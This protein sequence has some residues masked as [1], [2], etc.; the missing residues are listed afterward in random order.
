VNKVSLR[1]L[2]HDVGHGQSVHA[3]TPAGEVVVID[4]GCSGA[5]SPLEWL[6][7]QTQTID[8]LIITHPHG[9]HIDE[10]LKI[11]SLG[12]MVRQLWRPI[13]L[14]KEEVYKQNQESYKVKIERY[15]EISDTYNA[16]IVAG[17]RVGD[18][19]VSG[20]VS[21]E[22]FSASSCGVS[23]INNHSGVI[24]FNYS[25]S[26]IIIPGDN[27]PASWN[28]LKDQS[29][30]QSAVTNADIFMASHHGRSSGYEPALFELFKP[31]LCVVSDGR[32]QDTDATSRYSYHATGWTV[33]KKK[34][35]VSTSR[36]CLTTRSDGFI[37]INLGKNSN[38]RN[39]LSVTIL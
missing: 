26:K 22:Q 16:P 6:R 24:I 33:H 38:E 29:D 32:A 11:K 31:S 17:S 2:I 15:F 12:F 3:F 37:D 19:A 9:D 1:I 36:N 5:F 39:F 8:L 21:I 14:P 28:F 23:N 13:W 10:I 34:D 27:E 18:P 20:G 4:L 35:G 25:G 30:F 7:N